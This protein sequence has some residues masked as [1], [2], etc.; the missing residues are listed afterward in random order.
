[1]IDRDLIFDLQS[2]CPDEMLKPLIPEA[3]KILF[4][5]DP[6][7]KNM[8]FELLL[9][10][11]RRIALH[12]KQYPQKRPEAFSSFLTPTILI[13]AAETLKKIEP[14][15]I[16]TRRVLFKKTNPP[17]SSLA[18]A[19]VW[20]KREEKIG[21]KRWTDSIRKI[22]GERKQ[23]D[24]R[25]QLEAEISTKITE[26]K[27]IT[28]HEIE[29]PEYIWHHLPGPGEK[30]WKTLIP[31]FPGSPLKKLEAETRDLAGRTNFNQYSLVMSV[32]TGI[33]PLSYAYRTTETIGKKTAFKIEIFRDLSSKE[34]MKLFAETKGFFKASR[35]KLNEKH[36]R[37]YDFIEG[38][39][40]VPKKGVRKFWRTCKD[41]WDKLYPINSPYHY[42]SAEG[43]G[44][45]MAYKRI[46]KKNGSGR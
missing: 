10:L 14:Q 23:R 12:L 21:R 31:V 9:N 40:G 38:K 2:K 18:K 13:D 39:G 27:K 7:Y 8:P 36:L 16:E 30:G 43:E 29:G 4:G 37:I 41:E 44:L 19:L 35:K 33:K 6:A 32:L 46:L 5:E 24:R 20:I 22:G 28:G 26:L 34:F 3:T 45:R 42:R 25:R 1:M 17:F 15:L 11:V